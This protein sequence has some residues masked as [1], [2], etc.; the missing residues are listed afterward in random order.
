MDIGV[1]FIETAVLAVLFTIAVAAGSKIPVET[2]YDMPEPIVNRCLELGLID[3]SKRADSPQTRKK[4]LAAAI[5]IAFIIA[6]VLIFVNH[7]GNFLQGFLIS[8]VIRLIIDWYDCFVIDWI[9][10]CHSKKLI[11]PGTEDLVDSYKDYRFHFIGS[12][13]GMVIGFP[14]CL[15]VGVMVQLVNWIL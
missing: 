7:A 9:W 2:I 12:L 13:K 6:L 3:E 4:K 15:L 5:V 1:I 11:I 10:V 8:Y 14:V